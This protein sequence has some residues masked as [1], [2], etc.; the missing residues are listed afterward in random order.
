[1]FEDAYLTAINPDMI[2][3]YNDKE[4]FTYKLE[5][6]HVVALVEQH[7][8]EAGHKVSCKI[9]SLNLIYVSKSMDMRTAPTKKDAAAKNL[10]TLTH[11]NSSIHLIS[12]S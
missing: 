2:K 11:R 9:L 3:E 1:V 6:E 10:K 5:M 7:Y 8:V 12:P 4:E